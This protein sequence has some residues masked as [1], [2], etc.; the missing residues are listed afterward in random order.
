MPRAVHHV[1]PFGRDE[2]VVDLVRTAPGTK[3]Q[4]ATKIRFK[5][6]LLYVTLTVE[7]K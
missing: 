7:G 5:F 2:S 3:K 1:R 4:L 6:A